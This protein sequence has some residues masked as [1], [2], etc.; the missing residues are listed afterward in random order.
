MRLLE[1]TPAGE[2]RLTRDFPDDSIPKYTILSHT[3]ENEEVTFKDLTDGTGKNKLGYTKIQFCG[4]ETAN[5]K[6]QYFWVDTCCIDTSN[7]VEL[8]R[9]INSMFKWY[10]NAETCYVYLSDVSRPASD[11]DDESGHSR[12]KPAFRKSRWFTRGWTVQ[13]LIAPASVKFFSKERVLLGT[14]TSLEQTIHEITRI[15]LLAL[16]NGPLSAFSVSE[17]MAWMQKRETARAEDKAYALQG[18]F[19]VHMSPIYGEGEQSAFGRLKAEIENVSKREKASDNVLQLLRCYAPSGESHKNENP[20]PFPGTCEWLINSDEY[21]S[22]LRGGN[23][24]TLWISG[25]AACG[26]SVQARFI[27]EQLKHNHFSRSQTVLFY[28]FK[29]GSEDQ[30]STIAA[31]RSLLCQLLDQKEELSSLVERSFGASPKQPYDSYDALYI[32]L[33]SALKDQRC[34]DV[35]CVIDGVD[36]ILPAERDI[37]FDLAKL[38]IKPGHSGPSLSNNTFKLIFTVRLTSMVREAMSRVS[39][40]RQ[41]PALWLKSEDQA[42]ELMI[43]QD[44]ELY[45]RAGVRALSSKFSREKEALLVKQLVERA[46]TN[47]LWA[48]LIL[49][50]MKASP[51]LIGAVLDGIINEYPRQMDDLYRSLLGGT[52]ISE[53][54]RIILQLI[55]G[56][57][58]PMTLSELNTA[59]A[60]LANNLDNIDSWSIEEEPDI[61]RTVQI[62]CGPLVKIVDERVYLVH[63]TAKQYLLSVELIDSRNTP[64]RP[65]NIPECSA[66]LALGCIRYL[67]LHAPA[68]EGL[69]APSA[70]EEYPLLSHASKY[71]SLYVRKSDQ[72]QQRRFIDNA[73]SLLNLQY[74]RSK[75]WFSHYWRAARP[76]QPRPQTW[77]T[78]MMASFLG[79]EAIVDHLLQQPLEIQCERQ[80]RDGRTAMDLAAEAGHAGV[81]N[82]LL[83]SGIFNSDHSGDFGHTA[84]HDAAAHGHTA[85]VEALVEARADVHAKTAHSETALHL[86]AH[87]GHTS[88]V[89]SLLAV[90]WGESSL[91]E[92]H[93]PGWTAIHSAADAGDIE[94]LAVLMDKMEPTRGIV[95]KVNEDGYTALHLAAHGRLEP[96]RAPSHPRISIPLKNVSFTKGLD[97]PAPRL[98]LTTTLR[99]RKAEA[100]MPHYNDVILRLLKHGADVNVETPDGW[101]PLHFAAKYGREDLVKTLLMA[102]AN[103]RMKTRSGLTAYDYANLEGHT[104]IARR[105]QQEPNCI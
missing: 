58:T 77:T 88:T 39:D 61:E 3:W 79:L 2:I 34:G 101:T 37:I 54:G 103:V 29:Q 22:L 9:A 98:K 105:L 73:L 94:T 31:I 45:I 43:K 100:K 4:N 32:A 60:I 62:L 85:I 89:K 21:Q 66:A 38:C 10:K 95:N 64:W 104:A 35:F 83:R 15:P 1:Q 6:L 7:S 27:V 18:I 55:V 51:S 69:L 52:A 49:A 8:S 78:L 67:A 97:L 12:W 16:R 44:L 90:P 30:N 26:K 57:A 87:Y 5:D 102:R 75:I 74:T 99:P 28:F 76:W 23:S 36:Q 56:S 70:L 53:K 46:D 48:H 20:P 71:W 81:L 84:L 96:K 33:Q 72:S 40:I 82:S 41:T 92:S 68:L 14:R 11:V 80:G 63:W 91:G 93:G 59:F 17:R 86:A 25:N 65:L 19:D 24:M 47:F 42:A 13:E 50:K